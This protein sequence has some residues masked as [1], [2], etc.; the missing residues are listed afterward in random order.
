MIQRRSQKCSGIISA[1]S[2]YAHSS[3]SYIVE[4]REKSVH[5]RVRVRRGRG[6]IRHVRT[7]SKELERGIISNL[8]VMELLDESDR[9]AVSRLPWFDDSGTSISD[10]SL[11]LCWCIWFES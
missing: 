10:G 8:G 4:K 6:S 2:W 7:H 3:C 9:F 5:L 1:H 11:A